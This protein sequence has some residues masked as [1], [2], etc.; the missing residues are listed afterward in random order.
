MRGL[1]W[2]HDG[3]MVPESTTPTRARAVAAGVLLVLLV[4]SIGIATANHEPGVIH[5]CVNKKTKLVRIVRTGTCH[6]GERQRQWNVAGV[7]GSP[8]PAGSPGAA[9]PAGPEGPAGAQGVQGSPGPI[10]SVGP[11]G[12]PGTPAEDPEYAEFFALMP[13]D[14]PTTVAVGDAVEFPQ[15]GSELGDITRADADTFVLASTGTYRVTFVVSVDEAGQLELELN[16][17][18]V[19]ST[20]VGRATGTSQIVGDSLITAAAGDEIEVVNPS[21]NS[22]ALTITPNA[23]G[24]HAVVASLIIEKL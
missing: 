14:N 17:V 16:G 6:D 8:G 9:G 23:G 19:P 15:N 4:G 20:V 2:P 3:L 12:P 1:A 7:Q 22:T 10:G 5:A 18:G 11:T 24:T 21:G 13:P